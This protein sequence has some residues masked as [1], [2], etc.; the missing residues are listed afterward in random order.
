MEHL[1]RNQLYRAC[2][3][4]YIKI[5]FNIKLLLL[6][7]NPFVRR[8][9]F[10]F[11]C[12][13][14]SN[15]GDQAQTYC[16]TNWINENYPKHKVVLI[17]HITNGFRK[18]IVKTIK[19]KILENDLIFGHSGYFMVDH[20]LGYKDFITIS[21][22]F[23]NRRIVIFPQ[24]INFNNE[25]VIKEISKVFNSHGKIFLMCRDK[26]SYN[27]AENLF[28]S[29]K[30]LLF[31]DVV[32]TL[33]GRK[34]ISSNRNGIL[35][36]KRSDKEALYSLDQ[37]SEIREKFKVKGV[38]TQITDTSLDLPFCIINSKRRE[39]IYQLVDEFSKYQ[40]VITDRYHGLIFSL[41]SCT[42]V[43][44]LSSN[45]HKLTSGIEWFPDSMQPYI[46]H[47]KSV[48]SIFEMSIKI[49]SDEIEI[50]TSNYF[51]KQYYKG[52]KNLIENN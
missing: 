32:T 8:K 9:A 44:V 20:H 2:N 27:Y 35:F 51:N 16:I 11:G 21:K 14:H 33:I 47:A 42:P 48:E 39:L 43:I 40:L 1:V 41:I 15:M 23:K 45:D 46:S 10:V 29:C 4:F 7:L 18:I 22:T 25:E 24:T 5:Y 34:K 6:V 28:D 49:L 19:L 13:Q 17:P 38:Y 50:N 26:I 30:L 36:V 31:P 52:L 3:S 37:I 12:P